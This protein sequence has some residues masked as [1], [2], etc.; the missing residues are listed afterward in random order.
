MQREKSSGHTLLEMAIVIIVLGLIVAPMMA[1]Y[2][3]YKDQ[4]MLEQTMQ[5]VAFIQKQM[6]QYKFAFGVFPCP[7]ALNTGPGVGS[8]GIATDCSTTPTAAGTCSDGL[9]IQDSVVP[10]ND[11]SIP[12]PG[13][14]NMV[15]QK[16]RIGG[17]PFLTLGINERY[18][19]DGYGNKLTYAVTEQLASDPDDFFSGAGG[20]EVEDENGNSVLSGT[21]LA[22]FVILSHGKDGNG[23]HN[24]IGAQLPCNVAAK[25]GEN[26]DF[27]TGTNGAVFSSMPRS[28]TADANHNDDFIA[29]SEMSQD[30]DNWEQTNA[31]A[32]DISERFSSSESVLGVGTRNFVDS[33]MR[34]EIDGDVLLTP[35]VNPAQGSGKI[36]AD[37]QVDGNG[38]LC[39]HDNDPACMEVRSLGG[40]LDPATLADGTSATGGMGCPPGEVMVGIS[41]NKAVCKEPSFDCPNGTVLRGFDGNGKALCEERKCPSQFERLCPDGMGFTLPVTEQGGTVSMTDRGVTPSSGDPF[42]RHADY[43]CEAGGE[44]SSPQNQT[45]SCECTA[46]GAGDPGNIRNINCPNRDPGGFTPCQGQGPGFTGSGTQTYTKECPSGKQTWSAVQGCTCRGFQACRQQACPGGGGSYTERATIVCS[47]G[48][49]KLSGSWVRDNA[50][51]NACPADCKE[52]TK[53]E[54]RAC[55]DGQSGESWRNRVTD[56]N[57]NVSYTNWQDNC[58]SNCDP[59]QTREDLLPCTG[60]K[61]SDPNDKYRQPMRYNCNSG[62]WQKDGPTKGSCITPSQDLIWKL[63]SGSS[64]IQVDSCPGG[65]STPGAGCPTLGKQSECCYVWGGARYK[66]MCRCEER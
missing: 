61:V 14:P 4:Q 11:G 6:Q 20:I 36:I 17:V 42:E 23:A 62:K 27:L 65:V 52:T 9:C 53:R 40:E 43:T 33:D 66:Q 31:N 37:T 41:N 13:A 10:V 1:L 2:G 24:K 45:G 15:T 48:K 28:T 59:N 22:Q 57:G 46:V 47:G 16:I 21:G 29:Y 12:P 56:C 60:G 7:S 50:E 5:N 25:D 32:I 64:A 58:G 55:P 26:C 38:T 8:Y 39:P 35:N 3:R 54:T 30:Q 63:M 34:A 44:W 18:A 51:Y 49:H 19:Y